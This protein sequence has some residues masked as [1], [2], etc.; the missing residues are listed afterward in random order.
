MHFPQNVF[1]PPCGSCINPK[2]SAW[3]Q[4]NGTYNY[5]RVSF[6]PPGCWVLVH[7]CQTPT[8]YNMV[9]ACSWQLVFGP[10]CGLLPMLPCMDV[11]HPFTSSLKFSC[12]QLSPSPTA[13][14][15]LHVIP[16]L[17]A[18]TPRV[19]NPIPTPLHQG[20]GNGNPNPNTTSNPPGSVPIRTPL[21]LHPYYQDALLLPSPSSCYLWHYHCHHTV[22]PT[23]PAVLTNLA[24]DTSITSATPLVTDF[25]FHGTTIKELMTCSTAPWWA[26]AYGL[27]I[28][29][30]FQGLGP[31][32]TMPTGTYC[33][34]FINKH[35]MPWHKRATYIFIVCLTTLK[36]QFPNALA[37]PLGAIVCYTWE[38][39]PPR[40]WIW[41]LLNFYLTV[42][43]AHPMDVLWPLTSRIFI[44]KA[45][46]CRPTTT[47][48]SHY[49]LSPLTSN[50]ST[51]KPSRS[52]MVMSTWK[53]AAACKACLRLVGLP[54]TNLQSFNPNPNM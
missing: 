27:E 24:L 32:F 7:A 53:Y 35:D 13:V 47:F 39:S 45:I 1:F 22:T 30:L 21:P 48:A 6:V 37:G 18:P 17:A 54:M 5:N 49:G 41:L 44:S 2:L 40:L 20:N 50:P 43:S 34:F 19:R 26:T 14:P 28:G 9:S 38:M 15:N 23:P 31:I 42:Q 11:G 4:V 25:C 12:L 10:C 52:L 16:K 51:I 46:L 8:P 29:W 36:R 3:A 33:C